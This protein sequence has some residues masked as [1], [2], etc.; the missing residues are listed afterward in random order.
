MALQSLYKGFKS[1]K[2]FQDKIQVILPVIHIEKGVKNDKNRVYNI[3][4][5]LPMLPMRQTTYLP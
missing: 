5:N 4:I 3:E 1:N 2:E